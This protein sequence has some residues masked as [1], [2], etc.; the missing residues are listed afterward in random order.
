VFSGE[1]HFDDTD[2]L[3]EH[4]AAEHRKEVVAYK[5]HAATH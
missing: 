5:E 4:T 3:D 1:D 2:M